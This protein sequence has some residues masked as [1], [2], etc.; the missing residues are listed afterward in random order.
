VDLRSIGRR[1]VDVTREDGSVWRMTGVYGE[2]QWE[3]KKET[4]TL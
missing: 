4:W 1:Y 3:R 2:S